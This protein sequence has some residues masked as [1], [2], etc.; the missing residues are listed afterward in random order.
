MAAFEPPIA[1]PFI[2][3]E[4]TDVIVIAGSNEEVYSSLSS[5]CQPFNGAVG[6]GLNRDD[7]G[8]KIGA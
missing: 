6:R 8:L 4:A 7:D 3:V 5:V 2:T 1:P